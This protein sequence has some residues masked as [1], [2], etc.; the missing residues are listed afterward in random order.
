MPA[1]EP[2]LLV[3]DLC[4]YY[5]VKGGLLG[6]PASWV[7][8]VDGVS[9]Y[10]N[11]GE[12]LGLVG[13]SGCGKTT[14]GRSIL[15]LTRPTGGRVIFDGTELGRLGRSGLRAMRQHMQMMFENPYASLDPTMTV[16]EIVTEPLQIHRLVTSGPELEQ[17]A[18]ELLT[19]V[20]LDP[21]IL[22]RY[23]GEFSGGQRQRIELARA[24]SLQPKFIVC[25]NPLAHLDVSIQGQLVETLLWLRNWR[26]LT[27]LFI[28]HD[29]S[30]VRRLSHRLAVMY[31][32]KIM[33]TGPTEEVLANPL[34]PYTRALIS[35]VPV[36]DPKERDR[37][38]IL[39]PGEP[40]SPISPP[41]GCRFHP[42]C[43]SAIARCEHEAPPLRA[44]EPAHEVA[45]HLA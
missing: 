38:I 15:Y 25:D 10:I 9:L 37:R 22:E 19:L 28:T 16:K 14:L 41:A 4:T 39:L 36:P 42:R 8:A 31:L 11:R 23:P 32:G 34:H 12:T 26:N 6:R 35:A 40:P 27:Y 44:V 3:E 30:L 13:E 45:C 5:P 43:H 21:D 1:P 29:L 2:L 17:R 33:E 20:R 7:R 18:R 24:L